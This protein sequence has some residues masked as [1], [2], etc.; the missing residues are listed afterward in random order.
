M[1]DKWGRKKSTFVAMIISCLAQTFMLL[2]HNYFVRTAMFFVMGLS[3]IKVG[4]SYVWFSECVGYPY[5]STAF[6]IINIFDGMTLAVQSIYFLFISRNW[7]WL[8]LFFCGLSYVATVTITI[9]PE[10]PRWHLV[11]GRA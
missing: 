7:F 3:Q 4:I 2:S 8:P 6:T 9:C 11:N 5:K 10:S 1:P